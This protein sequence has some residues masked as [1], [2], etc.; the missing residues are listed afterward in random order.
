[1]KLGIVGLPNVGKSTLLEW[2][3]R[4]LGK[5]YYQVDTKFPSSKMCNRCGE[6]TDITND[7]GVREWTCKL[8]GDH[9]D[10]ENIKNK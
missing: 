8:C 2:K 1:M 10:R 7:L 9:H 6:K 4:V 3:C 5:Y